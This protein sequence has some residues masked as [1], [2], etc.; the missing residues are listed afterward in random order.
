[1]LLDFE[2]EETKIYFLKQYMLPKKRGRMWDLTMSSLERMY[3]VHRWG[4]KRR[5]SYL[6]LCRNFTEL[7]CGEVGARGDVCEEGTMHEEGSR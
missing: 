2:R 4:C 3:W 6:C 1:M 7:S 5:C